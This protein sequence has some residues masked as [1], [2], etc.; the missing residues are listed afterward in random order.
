MCEAETCENEA[1]DTLVM[2]YVGVIWS[3]RVCATHKRETQ[4]VL[5]G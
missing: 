2:T 1:T 4:K 5:E 3:S